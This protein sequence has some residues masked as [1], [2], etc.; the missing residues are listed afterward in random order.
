[1]TETVEP[2]E[3]QPK[4]FGSSKGRRL[5]R[6]NLPEEFT[7]EFLEKLPISDIRW[8]E[9]EAELTPRQRE[10]L[11]AVVAEWIA[12]VRA[13]A[14]KATEGLG[15]KLANFGKAGAKNLSFQ[16][17]FPKTDSATDQLGTDMQKT[18]RALTS[19]PSPIVAR[20]V[21]IPPPE[22]EGVVNRHAEQQQSLQRLDETNQQMVKLLAQLVQRTEQQHIAAERQKSTNWLLAPIA[23]ASMVGTFAT[24]QG[25]DRIW[26]AII[27][28]A[29]VAA[30]L[31]IVMH[32]PSGE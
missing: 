3:P 9:S 14:S 28:T 13:A 30:F 4:D 27:G 5:D 10:T 8:L 22:D 6:E 20:P 11:Q 31:Y 21:S 19:Q 32:T 16:W 2:E 26:I 24:V 23:A 1:M 7:S 15:A 17:H 12:P 29:A 18:I 25:G